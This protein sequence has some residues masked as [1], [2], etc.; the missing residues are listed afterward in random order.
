MFAFFCFFVQLF[1]CYFCVYDPN[2]GSEEGKLVIFNASN[3]QKVTNLSSH[4]LPVR[5]HR[6]EQGQFSAA[7]VVVSASEQGR[8]DVGHSGHQGRRAGQP[9]G[10]HGA[11]GRQAVEVDRAANAERSPAED[12]SLRRAVSAVGPAS[13]A[14]PVSRPSVLS[15]KI[16]TQR[17]TISWRRCYK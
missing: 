7:S 5:T 8:G 14:G 12:H 17:D 11:E 4:T 10:L 16:V 15:G 2:V 3:G 6:A 1:V 13:R 9:G